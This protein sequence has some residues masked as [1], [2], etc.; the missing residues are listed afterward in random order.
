MGDPRRLI[1]ILE[2]LE[3]GL[4]SLERLEAWDAHEVLA[5]V[6]EDVRAKL[7]SVELRHESSPFEHAHE[8]LRL[9][10]KVCIEDE[11][12]DLAEQVEHFLHARE[13]E[14]AGRTDEEARRVIETAPSAGQAVEILQHCAGWLDRHDHREDAAWM[15]ELA[16]HLGDVHRADVHR[17]DAHRADAHR[18]EQ[19]LHALELALHAFLEAEMHDGADLLERALHA[20]RMKL[21]GRTD[22][23]AMS[24]RERAPR[25][26]QVLDLMVRAEDLWREWGHEDRAR[27]ISA[28][29]ERFAER[30]HRAPDEVARRVAELEERVHHLSRSLAEVSADLKRL[31]EQVR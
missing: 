26:G 18:A 9:A 13:L 25:V 17:A 15:R 3:R 27:A 7:R 11:R 19:E 20:R 12:H 6:A 31:R 24:V 28:A 14:H 22:P 30:T 10:V 1:E 16:A 5:R 21:E 29:T 4:V 23:E 2:G 8:L